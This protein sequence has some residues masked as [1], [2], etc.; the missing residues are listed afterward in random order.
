MPSSLQVVPTAKEAN[1]Q[2]HAQCTM[3]FMR[4]ER[5]K[6]FFYLLFDADAT[7]YWYCTDRYGT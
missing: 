4:G 6:D 5:R 7:A 1:C 3:L 2:C